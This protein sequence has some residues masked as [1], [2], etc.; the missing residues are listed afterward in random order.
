MVTR[1]GSRT[2]ETSGRIMMIP[3]SRFTSS[4]FQF[5]DLAIGHAG[6]NAG[7]K[8]ERE[9]RHPAAAFVQFHELHQR[10][11][12]VHLKTCGH[13]AAPADPMLRDLD[14]WVFGDPATQEAE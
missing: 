5:R 2:F 1:R 11:S 6:A 12:L 14:D 3:V 4:G 10:A 13:A 7:E 9:I 8:A